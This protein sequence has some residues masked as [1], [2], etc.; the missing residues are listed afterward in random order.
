MS[1]LSFLRGLLG[2]LTSCPFGATLWSRFPR[3]Y[4]MN[5]PDMVSEHVFTALQ[6]TLVNFFADLV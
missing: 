2:F 5:D 3:H 1:I 4:A 6:R